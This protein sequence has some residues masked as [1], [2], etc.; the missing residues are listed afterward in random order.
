MKSL[1][2]WVNIVMILFCSRLHAD[3]QTV[4]SFD[5][6]ARLPLLTENNQ[7]RIANN[8]NPDYKGIVWG[9][10]IAVFGKNFRICD[11]CPF[12]GNPRSGN[13]AIT[14]YNND[15][16]TMALTTS[17]ILVGFWAGQNEYYGYG[18][19]SN[20]IIVHAL[21]QNGNSLKSV[22]FDLPDSLQGLAE[23]L[24]YMD[25]SVFLTCSGIQSYSI[26]NNETCTMD[27]NW[28]ADDFTFTEKD[29]E[30]RYTQADLDAKYEAGKQY[31]INNPQACGINVQSDSDGC[32]ILED[33]FDITMPCIDVFGTRLPIGLEI[34]TNSEDPFGYYWK[35]NLQ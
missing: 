7:L 14:N 26:E 10:G 33:N 23:P 31:C 18:G 5:D 8:D 27:C 28:V 16:G 19:G 17:K 11:D 12:F 35:L 25:T 15:L 30:E 22:S 13:Y 4:V 24:S 32:A 20:Q 3:Q 2:C 9:D 21:D 6:L 1:I 29:N 34:F